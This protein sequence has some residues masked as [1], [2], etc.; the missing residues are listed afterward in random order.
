VRTLAGDL[1]GLLATSP[2]S[3]PRSFRWEQ[4]R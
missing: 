4:T 2:P 3:R 1:S